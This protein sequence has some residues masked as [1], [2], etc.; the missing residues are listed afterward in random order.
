MP[1]NPYIDWSREELY[2]FCMKQALKFDFDPV[3][4][5]QVIFDKR[6]NPSQE[7]NGCNLVQDIYHPFY[8][9][10]KHDFDWIVGVGGI[11]ADRTFYNNLKK[12]G[13][14]TIKARIWFLGVRIGWL[15]F[16]KWVKLL[17]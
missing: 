7:F 16:Y 11:E 1:K 14:R 15:L 9:C 5:K 10:L 6:W 17:K 4:V 8:A 12:S 2:H 3:E 13:M